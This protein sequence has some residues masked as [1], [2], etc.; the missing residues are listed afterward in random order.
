MKHH[1]EVTLAGDILAV[2]GISFLITTSRNIQFTTVEKLDSKSI[3]T[4]A[5][6]LVKVIQLYK[7]RG[8]K[9]QVILLD[10]EFEGVRDILNGYEVNINICAPNEHIPEVERKIRT[11]KE[12]ARGIL[13]TLPF[14]VIP[15]I[16]IVHAIIFSVMWINF[17]PPRYSISQYLS[18]QAIVT[19]LSADAEKHCKMPF[20]AYAQVH[21][22]PTPSNDA[23][24]SRTVG[25]I[26]LGPTGNMQG[27]YKFLSLLT[28]R[29]I[30]ARSFT[31]LPM[32]QEV[33]GLVEQMENAY[34]DDEFTDYVPKISDLENNDNI[35]LDVDDSN[36]SEEELA[37]IQD[38]Q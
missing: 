20:G 15:T 13:T 10:N 17:F 14:K 2:G 21:G 23:M 24:T 28:K 31:P 26:S 29:M 9:V 35:T 25:G 4:L 1:R 27:T 12:R 19:G 33:I 38:M 32:P 37:D 11:V 16:I 7:R 36:I 18:P 6:G 30:K 34:D 8:F 22:E 3:Q 5:N